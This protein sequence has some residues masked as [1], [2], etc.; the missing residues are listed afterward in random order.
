MRIKCPN[1]GSTAQVE[2]VWQD[3]DNYGTAHTY[4]YECGCGCT[5]EVTFKVTEI[6]VLEMKK[7]EEEK[8]GHIHCPANGYDCP[9]WKNGKCGL[10][11]EKEGYIDPYEECADFVAFWDEGDDYIDYGED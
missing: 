2:L 1:C 3:T 4:E 11:S 9:Y 8:R 10:W 5:F 6:K 7:K